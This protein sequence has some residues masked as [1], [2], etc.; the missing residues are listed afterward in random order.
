MASYVDIEAADVALM[1]DDLGH[2]P[3]TFATPG[4]PG[5]S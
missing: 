1:G 5:G 3:D 4:G 2:L